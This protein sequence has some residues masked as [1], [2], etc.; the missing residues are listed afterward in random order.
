MI[1][2]AALTNSS[3]SFVPLMPSLPASRARRFSASRLVRV[4][5]FLNSSFSPATCSRVRP[6]VFITSEYRSSISAASWAA[7]RSAIDR[8]VTAPAAAVARP[9]YLLNFSPA[10]SSHVCVSRI[11]AFTCSMRPRTACSC[12]L[13]ATNASV[14]GARFRSSFSRDRAATVSCLS[15]EPSMF[16]RISWKSFVSRLNARI[17]ASESL[18]SR[19]RSLIFFVSP[20]CSAA[21]SALRSSPAWRVSAVSVCSA[22]LPFRVTMLSAFAVYCD[23]I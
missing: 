3:T 10:R 7:L 1:L 16:D 5:I 13:F 4:S 12:L 8:P 19:S 15:V 6:V 11:F 21:F 17:A 23:P 22:A 9:K 2:S 18:M 14:S 20:A